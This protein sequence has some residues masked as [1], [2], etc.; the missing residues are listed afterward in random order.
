MKPQTA[1]PKYGVFLEVWW[2]RWLWG[3][4]LGALSYT[5]HSAPAMAALVQLLARHDCILALDATSTSV[6]VGLLRAGA[7]AVW[8][9]SSEESGKA[10]FSGADACLRDTGLAMREVRAFVFCEGPGS[11]LGVRTAAMA[12][13]TWQTESPRPAYHYQSLALLAH[14]L[15][16]AGASPPFSVIADA[17]RDTWHCVS[18]T[19]GGAVQTL[20]RVPTAELAATTG[21]LYQPAAFRAWAAP[22][23]AAQD[24]TYEAAALFAAHANEELFTATDAPDAFQHEAPEYR[25]WSA[26]VHRAAPVQR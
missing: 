16:R 18:V 22:P 14:E 3:L 5:P 9:A 21:L 26:Q 23:R 25:K 19:A 10:L 12:I 2:I 17:R 24:C 8:H 13:R 11:L 7:P 15:R 6:Q 20:R 4:E 1:K